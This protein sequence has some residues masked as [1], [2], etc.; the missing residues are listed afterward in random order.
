MVL[1]RGKFLKS[2]MWICFPKN[3]GGVLDRK[4]VPEIH[5][6]VSDGLGTGLG[7]QPKRK[8]FLTGCWRNRNKSAWAWGGKWFG[9][10]MIK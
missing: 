5:C 10:T 8:G 9:L 3:Q 4:R 7:P 2:R 6:K 1:K